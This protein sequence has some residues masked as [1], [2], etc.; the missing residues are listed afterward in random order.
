MDT[1]TRNEEAITEAFDPDSPTSGIQEAID[2]L[3]E[4]GGCVRIPAGDDGRLQLARGRKPR[5]TTMTELPNG[6]KKNVLKNFGDRGRDWIPRFPD[7][8]EE[9]RARW[10]L[11]LGAPMEDLSINYVTFAKTETG[12]EV[13]LKIGVPHREMETEI[14]ALQIYNGRRMVRCLDADLR[15]G[16][17]LLKRITP[18]RMLKNLGNNRQEAQIA[19]RLMKELPV[20]APEEHYLPTFAQWTTKAFR[21]TREAFGPEG[22]PLPVVLLDQA[23]QAFKGIQDS[24]RKAV[25]LHGDLHHENILYDEERGWTAIDPKGVIGDPC[26]EV[27]RYLHNQLPRDMPLREKERRIDERVEILSSELGECEQRIRSCGF[28]DLILALCWSVEEISEDEGFQ[29]GVAI[30]RLLGREAGS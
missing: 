14:E 1:P 3:E 7:I 18:G 15:L 6:F 27:G 24:G 20:P 23:E 2:A 13:V 11:T 22:G 5:V 29:N 21:R 12:E 10:R 9:C 26:L 4:R 16:A 8:L 19:A 25:L 30:A 17:I 28:V